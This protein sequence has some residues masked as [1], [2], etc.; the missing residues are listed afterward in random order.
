MIEFRLTQI[1][2][3]V[4]TAGDNRAAIP[5]VRQFEHQ[6]ILEN[7]EP[8]DF[9]ALS[10][11]YAELQ[12]QALEQELLIYAGGENGHDVWVKSL[13]NETT[14][15]LRQLLEGARAIRQAVGP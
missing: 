5:A 14:P 12:V 13:A 1:P 4:R 6:V 15:E 9:L 3:L 11:R 7:L 8:L 2:R 10:R